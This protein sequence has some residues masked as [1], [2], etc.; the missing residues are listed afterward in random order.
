MKYRLP[1]DAKVTQIPNGT[2]V[3]NVPTHNWANDF[4]HLKGKTKEEAISNAIN[5]IIQEGES[6]LL[7][8]I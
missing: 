7:E 8:R 5:A 6:N 4:Y 2:W 3:C 1:K